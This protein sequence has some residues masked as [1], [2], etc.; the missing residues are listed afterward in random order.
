MTSVTVVF[1][2]IGG[3]MEECID[4]YEPVGELGYVAH[5][6]YEDASRCVSELQPRFVLGP[7]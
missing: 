2:E 7:G 5:V 4:A 3:G 6:S 1:T